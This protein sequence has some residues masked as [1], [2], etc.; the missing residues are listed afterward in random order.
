MP[1]T[2]KPRPG[3]RR[4]H[5]EMN[6]EA[7]SASS[8]LRAAVP[9][10]RARVEEVQTNKTMQDLNGTIEE[11]EKTRRVLV[12]MTKTMLSTG[13]NRDTWK[14][15]FEATRNRVKKWRRRIGN[16]VTPEPGA[17]DTEWTELNLA[18]M[19]M[20]GRAE[21]PEASLILSNVKQELTVGGT[22]Q[23]RTFLAPFGY[24][25]IKVVHGEEEDKSAGRLII[26]KIP[27]GTKSERQGPSSSRD[28]SGGDDGQGGSRR[29]EEPMQ[30]DPDQAEKEDDRAS[31]GGI[32]S[33]DFKLF[34]DFENN[35]DALE[36]TESANEGTSF[37]TGA[38]V[39]FCGNETE[40]AGEQ[41]SGQF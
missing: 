27:E 5:Q 41:L 3:L 6:S 34:S 18:P 35:S 25:E 38:S 32:S 19:R 33:L 31:I 12:E 11:L 7:A 16:A 29:S 22:L 26:P 37:D 39:S 10:N 17:F 2:T 14:R 15:L 30:E 36:T 21:L 4:L 40:F 1:L 28:A 9:P 24:D 20:I 23:T 13:E 8:Q